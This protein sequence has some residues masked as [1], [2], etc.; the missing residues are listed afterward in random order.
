MQSA[1]HS[2]QAVASFTKLPVKKHQHLRD[3]KDEAQNAKRTMREDDVSCWRSG[4]AHR[5]VQPLE[6]RTRPASAPPLRA[7]PGPL[8]PAA[9]ATA[10]ATAAG[11]PPALSLFC[12]GAERRALGPACRDSKLDSVTHCSITHTRLVGACSAAWC[13]QQQIHVDRPHHHHHHEFLPV[14][15]LAGQLLRRRQRTTTTAAAGRRRP[16]A[17]VGAGGR[18]RR[19][20]GGRPAAGLLRRQLG[21]RGR[22]RAAAG[23]GQLL[24]AAGVAALRAVRAGRRRPHP[25]DAPSAGRRLGRRLQSAAGGRRRPP[26]PLGGHRRPPEHDFAR[27]AHP[28]LGHPRRQFSVQVRRL[29]GLVAAGPQHQFGQ[30]PR[31]PGQ[32]QSGRPGGRGRRRCRSPELGLLHCLQQQLGRIVRQGPAPHLPLDEARPPRDE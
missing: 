25:P 19:A 26:A 13:L 29:D 15:Q 10:R 12:C 14:R 2:C 16:A 9:A 5:G 20:R 1:R 8:H 18:G 27:R 6:Q 4:G 7:P 22:R 30:H 32:P 21:L 23:G 17:A 31:P 11:R 3:Q 24:L 28:A